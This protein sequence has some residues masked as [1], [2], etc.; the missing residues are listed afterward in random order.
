MKELSKDDFF[1]KWKPIHSEKRY[2]F[3]E[4]IYEE[5]IC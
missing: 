4:K 5:N 1:I 3:M 2:K